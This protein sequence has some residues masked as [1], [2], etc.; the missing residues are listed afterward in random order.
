MSRQ[1][2][3]LLLVVIVA[4][5]GCGER[6]YAAPRELDNACSILAQRPSYHRAFQATEREWGVPVAV[7]MAIKIGRAHV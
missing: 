4:V 6:E 3:A 1:F 7:Q 5:S 2:R